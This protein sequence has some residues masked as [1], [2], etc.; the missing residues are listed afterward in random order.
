MAR[1]PVG[2]GLAALS[3]IVLAVASPELLRPRAVAELRS[4]GRGIARH[5]TRIAARRIRAVAAPSQTKP[6]GLNPKTGQPRKAVPSPGM[7][8]TSPTIKF[9]PGGWK[10]GRRLVC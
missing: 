5:H 1:T 7:G 4:A 9:V 3:V 6:I 2:T 8:T 10:Q